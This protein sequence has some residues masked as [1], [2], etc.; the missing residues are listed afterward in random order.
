MRSAFKATAILSSSS[1]LAIVVGLVS[2]K[3][4]AVYLQPAGYGYYGLLQAF[5]TVATLMVSFGIGTGLVRMGA[6][7]VAQGD[8]VTI[9][10][11]RRASWLLFA[12]LA[13]ISLLAV[14][15]L[16]VPISRWV[17]GDS[18]HPT[19]IVVMGVVL[20][21]T[22]AASLQT[23]TLNA[24]HRVKA[25]AQCGITTAV[26]SACVNVL[27][28]VLLSTGGIVPAVAGAAIIGWAVAGYFLRR[29]VGGLPVQPDSR[30]V[31]KEARFLLRFGGPY[32]A[33]VLVGTGVQYALPIVVLHVLGT[34]SVGYYRAA[35]AISVGY[36]GFLAT[37]MSQDYYPRIS[38]VK[39]RPQELVSLVN[40]QH[41]LVMILA[42]PLMLVMLAL[43]PYIV[44]LLYSR[45][46][47][48]TV[49]IL[50]WQLIGDI[51]KFSSWTMSFAILAHCKSSIYF[52]TEAIGGVLSVLALSL[53]I[54]W[55]G[56]PGLGIGFLL[57]YIMYYAVVWLTL[58]PKINLVW[59][60]S[61]KRMMFAAIAA[62]LFIRI[63]P[64]TRFASYRG[65]I[66]LLVAG[67]ALCAAFYAAG[68]ELELF[69]HLPLFR[70]LA[71]KF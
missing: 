33:S 21:F 4:M 25:L 14:W 36:L 9:S 46:F 11:L 2:S 63:L 56:L 23:A 24:Y 52:L 27:A 30:Q 31:I 10:V 65:G 68:R 64:S 18:D 37:A 42:V 43:V 29:E 35:T 40:E 12:G 28:V 26:L 6:G 13:T 70:K 8:Q 34:E 67:G 62:A 69:K 41:K 71:E 55:F 51:F 32:T 50:E 45:K 49:D 59:T 17:L 60:T 54:R 19:T 39:D 48:P 1:V 47:M 66:S 20:I 3:V 5:V 58:R 53:A 15:F 57:T 7:A 61:N 16:R 44:P 22:V 38:A